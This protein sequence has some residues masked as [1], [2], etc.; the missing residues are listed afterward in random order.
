MRYLAAE[1]T[2]VMEEPI[3][4]GKSPYIRSVPI[5]PRQDKNSSIKDQ[6]KTGSIITIFGSALANLSDGYQ[7][8]LASSTNVIFQHLLGTKTYTSSIQTRISNALLVGSVIG[9]LI[10]GYTSD[11]FSRKGGMLLT[12][13]LVIVGSLM[14][15]LAFQVNGAHNILWYFT[16]AR[17]AA[18]V[19]VG[20]EYPTSA[21]A[22]LEGSN[23]HFDRQRGPIQVLI[24]TLMVTSGSALCTFVYLMALIGSNNGLKVAFH[25][26][27]S[28]SVVL[29]LLVVL[30]RW[31]MQDGK[32]FERSNF[33]NRTIPW[34]L[35]IKK[36]WM[37]I[38]GTSSAFF[39]YDFVNFP[40]SIMSSVIINSLVPDK[41]VRTVALWQLYLALMP[42]P[43]V[44]LGSYLVNRIGRRWTGISGFI[45]GYI[46]CG[47]IIGGLYT[48]LTTA[49]YLP[50][51]VVLYGL[52]Q[53]FGHMGPGATIGLISCEAFPTA[54]RGMGYGIAAGF[55]K[56]GA[57][58][59][60]QVFTPIREAAGPEST[61]YVAAVIG[62][63]ASGI[64]YFLPEG[65]KAGLEK[66]DEEFDRMLTMYGRSEIR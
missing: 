6:R 58:V 28:V 56:A 37:R 21:A 12:S 45:G 48:R 14:S 34:T 50:A 15:V 2:P 16:I 31:R 42:I 11:R 27:Y 1:A 20:G 40:N 26:M 13:G 43:G 8:N 7:Q 33:R 47:F 53:A 54:A 61:F 66:N 35:L 24:S 52:L 65:N 51:F 38:I 55:G 41:N 25:A 32:L 46:I 39:L 59:G 17:G 23:E 62:I 18:G 64:Y 10:F 36:Y 30:A 22:A 44:L 5:E 4:N 29:P 63:L 9:I 49:R 57:A 3:D 19:G 60:T